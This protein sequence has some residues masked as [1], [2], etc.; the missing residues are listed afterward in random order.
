MFV[1]FLVIVLSSCI[2]FYLY[3]IYVKFFAFLYYFYVITFCISLSSFFCCLFLFFFFKQKT[4]YEMRISDWS[5]DVC[6]SDLSVPD[7]RAVRPIDRHQAAACSVQ[8][9]G[10][11]H[12][13]LAGR[14]YLVL[15][16]LSAFAPGPDSR[17]ATQGAQRDHSRALADASR[18]ADDGRNDSRLRDRKSTRLNSSH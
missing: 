7:Q 5:S 6:S 13:G 8:G 3:F 14:I 10:A 1:F 11:G 9:R 2:P 18:C 15:H 12:P 4:A 16:R 17:R